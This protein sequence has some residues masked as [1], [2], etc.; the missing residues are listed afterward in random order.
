M[1]R[2]NASSPP[3]LHELEAEVMAEVWR[4]GHEVTVRDVMQGINEQAGRERAYT[5][6]MTIMRKLASKGLLVR[7]RVGKADHYRARW[8]EAEY[9]AAR[10][11]AETAGLVERYGDAALAAFASEVD[12]LDPRHRRVLR[13]LARDA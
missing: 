4:Q 6:F 2:S 3:A 11:R 12:G 13:R 9:G 10:A 7:R 1:T 5:T 8:T